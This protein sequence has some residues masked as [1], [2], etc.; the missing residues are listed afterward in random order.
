MSRL[1]KYNKILKKKYGY[2]SLKSEQYNIID[3]I[4]NDKKDI[5]GILATGFGKSICYQMPYLITKKTVIVVSPLIA[6]M[7]DQMTE[8][9]K[10]KIPVAVLNSNC[11][12]K[13]EVINEVLEGE[14]KIIY[15]TPEYMENCEA[16]LKLLVENEQLC[17]V[18][19]DEAHCVSTWGLDFRKSY[20]LLK[21]IRDWIDDSVPILALTAT[22]SKKVRKDIIKILQL[23]EPETIVGDFDRKNLYIS[24]QKRSKNP[25]DDIGDLLEKFN[26]QYIIIYCKTR[27]ETEKLAE[28]IE[29]WGYKCLPYHAGIPTKKREEIQK[30]FIDGTIKIM[31]ATIAFGMGINIKNVRLVIHYNCPKN[32]ESYYQEIGRAGRDG[33]PSECHLFYSKKDFII[34]KLFLDGIKDPKHKTYQEEQ[35]NAIEKYVY[36]AICRRTLILKNFDENYDKTE[37]GNC[38]NCNQVVNKVVENKK[39]YSITS[40]II[41]DLISKLN[42]SYGMN[43]YINI[44]RGS[45]AKNITLYMKNLPYYSIGKS[46][47]VEWFKDIF[48]ALMCDS[49]L[50]EKPIKFSMGSVLECTKKAK[51]WVSKIKNNYDIIKT[52]DSDIEI[53]K[54]DK[55]MITETKLMKGIKNKTTSKVKDDIFTDDILD[56]LE[57]NDLD[58]ED[59]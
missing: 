24:V 12:N 22:A 15:I 23:D 32:M 38:D 35:I 58:I 27:E 21:N 42:G 59:D 31:A 10:L 30:Q 5:L 40:F 33:L 37:C 7:T 19:I 52:F 45:K 20:T 25:K 18:A 49:Y 11:K 29:S 6:L 57:V 48:N 13:E 50:N 36:T 4:V 8:L 54:E 39:D 2:D 17:L 28:I 34:N 43:T 55:I 44:I 14:N 3:K 53:N 56:R 46:Y 1:E 16:F 9:K 51:D 41:L 47:S 26:D